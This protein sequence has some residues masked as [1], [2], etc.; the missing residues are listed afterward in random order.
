MS[1]FI[2]YETANKNITR[3]KN[4]ENNEQAK[5]RLNSIEAKCGK[6]RHGLELEFL[7]DS[8]NGLYLVT[9]WIDQ[10]MYTVNITDFE[11]DEVKVYRPNRVPKFCLRLEMGRL[12]PDEEEVARQ[13]QLVL[14]VLNNALLDA[15]ANNKSDNLTKLFGGPIPE[16]TLQVEDV[17]SFYI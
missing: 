3:A 16:V 6:G 12:P 7:P 13:Q 4:D 14:A 5:Q 10:K 8:E 2:C 15:V 11:K 17:V 1:V 9:S